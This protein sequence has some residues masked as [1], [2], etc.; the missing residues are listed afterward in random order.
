MNVNIRTGSSG[1]LVN[2]YRIYKQNGIYKEGE[3]APPSKIPMAI[4]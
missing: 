1:Y 4:S 2:L 3:Q